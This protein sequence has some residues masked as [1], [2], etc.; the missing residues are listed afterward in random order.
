MKKRLGRDASRLLLLLLLIFLLYI[1]IK[2]LILCCVR[3]SEYWMQ[4]RNNRIYYE[5]RIYKS[6]IYF[7]IRPK[8]KSSH[9]KSCTFLFSVCVCASNAQYVQ[10]Y[11]KSKKKA[12]EKWKKQ[13][14][15]TSQVCS[16]RIS[17]E[18]TNTSTIEICVCV[19]S[20][21]RLYAF[22][23]YA[24]SVSRSLPFVLSFYHFRRVAP[25]F[26]S[27]SIFHF[28]TIVWCVCADFVL[29]SVIVVV[30]MAMYKSNI[31]AN[32]TVVVLVNV[33]LNVIQN[34]CKMTIN[35]RQ[36]RRMCRGKFNANRKT[37]TKQNNF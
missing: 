19:L 15:K 16:L 37:I 7:M 17:I 13:K 28:I 3:V 25:C 6:F 31:F 12:N 11:V 24:L 27:C 9:R 2:I 22:C 4:N 8:K 23:H 20:T 30:T 33:V 5:R 32:S 26:H 29:R 35:S 36:R 10:F 34:D 1:D 18:N 14:T 21:N